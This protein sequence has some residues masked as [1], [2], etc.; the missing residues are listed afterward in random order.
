ME[1]SNSVTMLILARAGSIYETRENN[2]ISHFLEHNFFKW[3]IRYKTPQE[4]AEA[5]DSF[6]WEFNAFTWDTYAW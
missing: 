3:W 1:D 4:V 5:V 6:G 2:W